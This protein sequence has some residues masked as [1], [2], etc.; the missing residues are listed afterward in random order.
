MSE[1]KRIARFEKNSADAVDVL[2]AQFGE[3]DSIFVT[4]PAHEKQPSGELNGIMGVKAVTSEIHTVDDPLL[5]SHLAARAILLNAAY[6]GNTEVSTLVVTVPRGDAGKMADY[7]ALGFSIDMGDTRGQDARGRQ[8][9]KE[10]ILFSRQNSR[11]ATIELNRRHIRKQPAGHNTTP[12]LS[13]EW[14]DAY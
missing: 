4:V 1:F 12:K 10:A 13:A 7:E 5:G 6:Q 11:R 2:R 8:L 9:G 14:K 3:D